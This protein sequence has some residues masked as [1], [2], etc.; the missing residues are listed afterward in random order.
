MDSRLKAHH[1][2][3][4]EKKL[5]DGYTDDLYKD[6]R[7]LLDEVRALSADL[8]RIRAIPTHGGSIED[9]TVYLSLDPTGVRVRATLGEVLDTMKEA[10]H[11]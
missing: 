6:C 1:T 10:D 5:D 9:K 7:A 3:E 11:G 2:D 8:A 4:I